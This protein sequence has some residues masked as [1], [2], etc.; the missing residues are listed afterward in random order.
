MR[1]LYT[2]DELIYYLKKMDPGAW[3]KFHD[4]RIEKFLKFAKR[5][6][7]DHPQQGDFAEDHVYEAFQKLILKISDFENIHKAESYVFTVIA[8][9]SIDKLRELKNHGYKHKIIREGSLDSEVYIH[10]NLTR[11]EVAGAVYKVLYSMPD[12][13]GTNAKIIRLYYHD[14]ISIKEIARALNLS[15]DAVKSRKMRTLE[16]LKE[17]F[18]NLEFPILI[19]LMFFN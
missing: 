18:K 15:E 5:F 19:I 16:K 6:F 8:N 7:P 17:H 13:D 4:D 2:D 1:E 9:S 12:P 3:K 14:E 11:T 10:E